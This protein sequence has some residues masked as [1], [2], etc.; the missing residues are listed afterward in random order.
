[1]L[2]AAL[3]TALITT[4]ELLPRNAEVAAGFFEHAGIGGRIDLRIGSL[5][6]V[7][8]SLVAGGAQFDAVFIDHDKDAYT[9]DARALLAA[10]VLTRGAVLVADNIKVPGAPRYA[11]WA[12]THPRLTTRFIE[13]PLE[14][15][16]GVPGAGDVV[17][18]SVVDG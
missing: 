17:A 9:P 8:P 2:A 11:A 4:V 3:P 16:A 10:G 14:W 13:A 18:V 15:M 6:S 5:P 7:L 1:M 12:S